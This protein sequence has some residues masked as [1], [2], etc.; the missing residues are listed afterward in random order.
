[1][2]RRIAMSDKRSAFQQKVVEALLESKAVDLGAVASTISKFA[3]QAAYE[4]E[5]LTLI[6]TRHNF[7]A[8]GWPGPELDIVRGAERGQTAR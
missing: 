1:M 4:S 3:Q 6:I 8:C 2:T 7:W 5:S